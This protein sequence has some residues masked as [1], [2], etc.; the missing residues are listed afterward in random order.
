MRFPINFL[1]RRPDGAPSRLQLCQP[2]EREACA[3]TPRTS[4]VRG[5]KIDDYLPL[6]LTFSPKG[7]KEHKFINFYYSVLGTN[8]LI[9]KTSDHQVSASYQTI[10]GGD[11]KSLSPLSL[12][13]K[14]F[15][16]F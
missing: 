8:K 2:R 3:F 14:T 11:K 10:K 9:Y 1:Q 7:E 13:K 15:I 5:N 6:N 12:I 4:Q 16:P